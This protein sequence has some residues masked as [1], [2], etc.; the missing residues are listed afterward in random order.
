MRLLLI[1]DDGISRELWTMMLEHEGHEV[2][3]AESGETAVEMLQQALLEG[4]GTPDVALTDLQLPGLSGG[5]LAAAIREVGRPRAE[6]KGRMLLLAMSASA[7]RRAV[8]KGFDGFLLKP[9]TVE[10]LGVAI[11]SAERRVEE[12][13]LLH[14]SSWGTWGTRDGQVLDEIVF[15]RLVEAMP[16]KQL[17]ELYALCLSDTRARLERMRVASEARHAEQFRRSAHEIMGACGMIGAAELRGLAAAM[18]ETGLEI[19]PM[20]VTAHLDR[21]TSACERLEDML[22]RRWVSLGSK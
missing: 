8:L 14:R 1:E 3:A 10:A 5:A 7:P 17:Q 18:E 19:G 21:F 20:G 6:R 13:A 4:L 22:G 11:S 15:R 16:P 9:F 2:W 12:G